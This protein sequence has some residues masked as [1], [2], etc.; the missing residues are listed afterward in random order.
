[1][2]IKQCCYVVSFYLCKRDDLVIYRLT[3][4]LFGTDDIRCTGESRLFNVRR[5]TIP[6]FCDTD[7]LACVHGIF[8]Q[9][10]LEQNEVG[11]RRI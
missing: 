11:G 3:M 4:V 8:Y 7:I 9:R 1:M 10:C 5:F 2:Y 6:D